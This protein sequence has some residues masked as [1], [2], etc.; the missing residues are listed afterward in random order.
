MN[1]LI[2]F[3][4]C[5]SSSYALATCPNKVD[6]KKVM[7]FVDVN[8]GDLEIE[9]ARNAACQRGERFEVVPKNYKDMGVYSEKINIASAKQK[10]CLKIKQWE[11]CTEENNAMDKA[12]TDL[13]DYTEKQIPIKEQVETRLAELNQE[14]VK[15]TNVSISGH[16]GGGSFGGYKGN[17]SRQD[18]AQI[19]SNY[20]EMNEVE[21]LLLLGCYTGVR[22][23]VFAWKAI[24]PKVKLIGG[25]DG[26]APNSTRPQG[27]DYISDIL[28]KEKSL[29]K[30]KNSSQVDNDV[31]GMLDGLGMLNAAV[32]INPAC[33]DNEDGF[34][35]ASKLNREFEKFEMT[36]CEKIVAE[37]SALNVEFQKYE[38]GEIEPPTDTGP[39][40][41]LRKIYDKVRTNEHCL[42]NGEYGLNSNS[43]F[44]LLFWEGLKKNFAHFYEDDML[45]AEKIL[46]TINPE[47][48]VKNL[49]EKYQKLLTD[50][51]EAEKMLAEYKKDPEGV[52]KKYNADLAMAQKEVNDLMASQEYQAIQKKLQTDPTKLTPED[53]KFMDK[54]SEVS[55]K[56][57][58]L[59]WNNP[60]HG[61]L[62][63]KIW[64]VDSEINNNR[65]SIEKIKSDPGFLKNIWAPT[66]ANMANKTRKEVLENMHNMHGLLG[67]D[68]LSSK[69]SGA[70]YFVTNV[71]DNH[72]RYFQNPF[73]WH[74]YTGNPEA[75]PNVQKLSSYTQPQSGGMSGG[76]GYGGGYAGG[77]IGGGMG[78]QTPLQQQ[79]QQMQQQ[80]QQQ[81]SQQQQQH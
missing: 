36:G 44:F 76:Y 39:N 51:E 32:Y 34:Y 64:I 7:L 81:N 41:A 11:K 47:D 75:V 62:E 45:E 54:L 73:S 40:G 22:H 26:S 27:L 18:L 3:L 69:Q 71:T 58:H 4:L 52:I 77:S 60:A 79:D 1:R 57:M 66:K 31:K 20:P 61:G 74:E 35:Y 70:L 13:R 6:N 28:T 78:G 29:T 56:S 5:V 10:A 24:F 72:L 23:E 14:K 80:M 25:Y 46:A 42:S 15:L 53:K 2:I 38:S 9:T 43:V 21:S 37:L 33:E 68:V 65:T 19:M 59:I 12:Y 30:L 55:T 49:D 50:K 67:S 48:M 63:Q 16:D 8:L 17:F